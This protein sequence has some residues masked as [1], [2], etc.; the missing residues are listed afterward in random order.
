MTQHIENL[1]Q[2]YFN[3]FSNKNIVEL[4]KMFADDIHLIDWDVNLMGKEKVLEFNKTLFDNV[5]QIQLEVV[6]IVTSSTTVYAELALQVDDVNL[7]V[8]DVIRFKDDKIV[9]L[10]AYQMQDAPPD[11][12]WEKKLAEYRKRDPFIYR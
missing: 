11:V 1:S 7:K 8:L 12:L 4:D 3:S 10:N 2:T 6:S 5:K 9:Q